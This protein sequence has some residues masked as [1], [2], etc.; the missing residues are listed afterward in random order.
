[1]TIEPKRTMVCVTVQRTCER[2]IHK[3]A[4]LAG[5]EDLRVVHVVRNG[6]AVLG[7]DNEP[8]ALDYLFRISRTFGAEMDM[9]RSDN[10]VDT[11][12]DFANKHQISYLVIGAG[13]N[14]SRTDMAAALRARLPEVRIFVIP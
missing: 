5:E 13:G 14:D 8:E 3:G 1:M 2:L 12:V 6:G 10:V 7:G 11:L 9:L 4:D